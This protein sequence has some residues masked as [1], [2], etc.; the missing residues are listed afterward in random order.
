MNKKF[1]LLALTIIFSSLCIITLNT[2]KI[3]VEAK[4]SAEIEMVNKVSDAL[5][6]FTKW[7]S[8]K[9]VILETSKEIIQNI[10]YDTLTI[11]NIYNDYLE[12][13]MDD[14]LVSV[15][16]IGLEDGRFLTGDDWIPPEGYDARNR[17]WYIDTV[18]KNCTTISDVYLDADSGENA[19][20]ISSPIYISNKFIGVL[21]ID[22]LVL[23][24]NEKLNQLELKTGTYAYIVTEE[25]IIIG[26]T[27]APD[28]IGRNF[29]ELDAIDDPTFIGSLFENDYDNVVYKVNGED[30]FAVTRMLPE[31]NWLI[32]IA[33]KSKDVFKNYYI[34]RV[35]LILNAFFLLLILT[36]IGM[37]YVYQKSM[38]SNNKVLESRNNE[39]KEAYKTIN[40]INEQLDYKS[41]IDAMTKIYNRGSFDEELE[42]Y[43]NDCLLEKK[44]IT[45]I[46]FDI[47]NFKKYNDHYGHVK[48]DQVIQKM[49]DQVRELLEPEDFFARYGGEEFII[50]RRDNTL[51]QAEK[52]GSKI[53]KTVY[54]SNMEH[55]LSPYGRVTVSLGVNS[56]IPESDKTIGYFIY[57]TDIAMYQAKKNGRNQVVN[58]LFYL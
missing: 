58:A 33:M 30:V 34:S 47:D 36:T 25:G 4:R 45:M 26:H 54:N 22:I 17:D 53:V 14:E 10:D 12:I 32:G 44:E 46:L 19:I 15:A 41:K 56:I 49:C 21:G 52:L 1:L 20:T 42:S 24:L 2:L 11:E 18:E 13:G 38:V 23:D 8:E 43:W 51:E 55:L 48:G 57:S 28:W 29:Y 39:L 9:I 7:V 27:L 3:N 35:T 31:S 50:I 16:Y 37:I 40:N 6:K 5:V